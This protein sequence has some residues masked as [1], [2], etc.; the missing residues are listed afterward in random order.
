MCLFLNKLYQLSRRYHNKLKKQQ[1]VYRRQGG[2]QVDALTSAIMQKPAGTMSRIVFTWDRQSNR[3]DTST[4]NPVFTEGKFTQQDIDRL[5][6]QVEKTPNYIP[7][8]PWYCLA[9]VMPIGIILTMFLYLHLL[10]SRS[11][12]VNIFLIMM[13]FFAGLAIFIAVP[14]VFYS[15]KISQSQQFRE[16]EFRN[17]VDSENRF[18]SDRDIRWTVGRLGGWL[19]IELDYVTRAI[20]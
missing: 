15:K 11:A 1:M 9:I 10:I 13:L 3:F 4:F 5:L 12:D 17:I 20:T 16:V 18:I 19:A 6:S 7:A 8:N 14:L 2:H